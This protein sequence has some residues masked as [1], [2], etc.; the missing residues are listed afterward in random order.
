MSGGAICGVICFFFCALPCV[1]TPSF[2]AF[3][4]YCFFFALSC[5][6]M[7]RKKLPFINRYIIAH[8]WEATDFHRAG[9]KRIKI[10]FA[11]VLTTAAANDGEDYDAWRFF[12]FFSPEKISFRVFLLFFNGFFF[13]FRL[14][15]PFVS[16]RACFSFF[17][18][19]QIRNWLFVHF[20]V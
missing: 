12:L 13:S 2:D 7:C 19:F 8:H 20:V 17:F 16:T 4:R 11:T 9:K 14:W 6:S 3:F 5:F 1:L 10:I 15:C 18:F